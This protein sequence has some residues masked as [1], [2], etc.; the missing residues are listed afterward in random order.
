[1]PITDPIFLTTFQG[2]TITRDGVT[3]VWVNGKYEVSSQIV[4]GTGEGFQV[5]KKTF[6]KFYG[7]VN[8]DTK[9]FGA[10]L[11][12]FVDGQEW[13]GNFRI[14]NENSVQIELDEAFIRTQR[15]I[16]FQTSKGNPKSRYC[17]K[18]RVYDSNDIVLAK[19]GVAEEIPILGTYKT[20]TVTYTPP[21]SNVGTSNVGT[22]NT[23]IGVSVNYESST[24]DIGVEGF[25]TNNQIVDATIGEVAGPTIL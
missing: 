19:I 24:V 22:S 3:Y 12:I 7:I 1:M 9:L 8:P 20:A 16:T 11:K 18:S 2:S 25:N 15:L 13:I 17:V 21:I 14:E 10:D 4:V 23:G 5:S 6:L